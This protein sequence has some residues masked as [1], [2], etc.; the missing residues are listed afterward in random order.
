MTPAHTPRTVNLFDL[1]ALQSPNPLDGLDLR[2][3]HAQILE[4]LALLQVGLGANEDV[5]VAPRGRRAAAGTAL[6]TPRALGLTD[7]LELCW[8]TAELQVSQ[9]SGIRRRIK[10]LPD[11]AEVLLYE[12]V[13]PADSADQYSLVVVLFW[14][15]SR[16]G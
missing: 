11:L 7:G 2:V 16:G 4:P 13:G 10:H 6:D 3:V 9:G 5:E 1:A 12:H 15:R 14:R 8:A